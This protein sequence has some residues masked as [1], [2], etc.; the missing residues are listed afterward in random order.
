V[1]LKAILHAA[2][3]C[4]VTRKDESVTENINLQVQ[5]DTADATLGL[6]GT[7]ASS[8]LNRALSDENSTNSEA[9]RARQGWKVGETVLLLQA[10]GCKLGRTV[11]RCRST[12]SAHT[13]SAQTYLSLTASTIL[14]VDPKMPDADW[15]RRW[16]LRQ[17][18]REALNLPF[19]EGVWDLQAIKYGPLRCLYTIGELDEF[20]RSAPAETFQG[21]MSVLL[22]EV[23]LHEVFR[24]QMLFSGECCNIPTYANAATATC[25]GCDNAVTLRLNPRI[26]GQ[27]L[28]ETA[29]ISAGKLLFSDRAWQDLL[30]RKS[31]ELLKLG[32]EEIRYLSDRLLFCR[33]TLL[34]GWTGD[35]GKAG[36]RICVLGV[37]C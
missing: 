8:P 6:W 37:Q 5:D 29:C 30:G 21:Y 17:R 33:I 28:D 3:R 13:D 14:D 34:F 20:A 25:K 27:V 26:I 11:S 18:S 19:P 16:S 35:E 15:L 31:E 10:T 12:L 24:R 9:V 4:T 36:G 7:N 1:V 32:H 23:K 2:D 22:A